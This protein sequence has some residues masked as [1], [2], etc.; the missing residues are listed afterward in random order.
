MIDTIQTQLDTLLKDVATV[1]HRPIKIGSVGGDT[2][3]KYA[4]DVKWTIDWETQNH[5][6]ERGSVLD[7]MDYWMPRIREIFPKCESHF[8][9][10]DNAT[11]W[12]NKLQFL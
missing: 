1:N 11:I 3:D 8:S 7:N 6:D 9:D 12:I 2:P 10:S 5:R 4:F